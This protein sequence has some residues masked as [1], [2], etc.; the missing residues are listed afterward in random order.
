M[1]MGL[2]SFGQA[3]DSGAGKPIASS[4]IPKMGGRRR[5]PENLPE[6]YSSPLPEVT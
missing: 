3:A 6:V 2:P 5:L 1:E 4:E